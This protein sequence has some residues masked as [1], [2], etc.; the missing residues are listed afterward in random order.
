MD[1]ITMS[2]VVQHGLIQRGRIFTVSV[3]LPDRPG[4]LVRVASVIAEQNGN[5]IK[6]EHNQFVSTNRNAAVELRVT[7][8]AYG[9][10]HKAQ[11][12]EAI[13]KAGFDPTLVQTSL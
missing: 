6:L 9:E 1:V 10:E 12:V 5:V 11:I 7:I 13:R 8:E 3:L 2:S 4:M